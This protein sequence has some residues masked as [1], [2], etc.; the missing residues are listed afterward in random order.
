MNLF[1]NSIEGE[2][3]VH[4]SNTLQTRV[5]ATLDP[6]SKPIKIPSRVGTEVERE[7][8]W[9]ERLDPF[10]VKPLHKSWPPNASHL[11]A[12]KL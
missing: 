7:G 3:S 12:M 6:V 1:F 9:D 4:T 8:M 2:S 11:K 10:L 5:I